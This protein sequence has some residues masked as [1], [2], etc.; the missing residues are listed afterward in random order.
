M[1]HW[2]I[3]TQTPRNTEAGEES[4]AEALEYNGSL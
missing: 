4:E 1:E 2:A 3:A